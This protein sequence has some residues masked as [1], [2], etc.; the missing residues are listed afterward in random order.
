MLRIN[1]VGHAAAGNTKEPFLTTT[2]DLG[3]KFNFNVCQ[4]FLKFTFYEKLGDSFRNH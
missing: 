4:S 2:L 1:R 3:R